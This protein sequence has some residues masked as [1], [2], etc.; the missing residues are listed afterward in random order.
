MRNSIWSLLLF[1]S[2]IFM[3]FSQT[4]GIEKGTY[5]SAAKGQ[6][7]KLNLL[8]DNKYELV[9][10][11][12][13]YEIKGDSLVFSRNPTAE[14]RFDLSFVTDKKAKNIKI[15]F[16]DPSYYSFYI[17]TQNG[18]EEI[19]YQ[20]IS[21]IKTKLDPEW[22]KTDL[23]FEIEKTD[24]LYLVYE[25]YD[26]NSHLEKYALPKDAA[27]ITIN[28]ELEVLGDLKL[29]GYYDKKTNELK[30]SE[31]GGKNP[32]VFLNEKEPQPVKK[33]KVTPLENQ[34]VSKWTYPGKVD[35]LNEDFGTGVAVDT[36]LYPPLSTNTE[37]AANF[38]FKLKIENNLKKAIESTKGASTNKY[39]VVLANDKNKSAKQSFD[40]FV[41]D[42][43]TQTGYNMYEAYNPQ[44]DVYNYYLA[45]ADDKK[46]LKNNKITN[47]PSVVV[48]NGNG[49]VLAVA[50]SDLADKSYH[51]NY[52]GDLYRKLLRADAFVTIDKIFKNKKAADADL[53]RAFNRASVLESS[54]D[55]DSDYVVTEDNPT[56]F[57]ITK[58]AVDKKEIA[59]TWKKLIEAHQKDTKPNLYLVE[60]IV[61]EIKN[62][63]FTKQLFN[64]DRILNDTDY[65]AID[66]LLK[67]SDAIEAER[68]AF[69]NKEGEIH[70]LGNV[71]SE[72]SSALQQNTYISQEGTSGEVNK[73][74]NIS[75]Y[76][77]I[78]A[79]GKGNFES[80]RNYFDYLSQIEDKDGSNTNFLKDFSTYFDSNLASEKGSPIEKLDAIYSSL[81][82]TSSYSY[83][84]WNSFKDYH[85]NLCN[86]TAWTVVLKPQNASFIKSAIVWSEY[87]LVVT[88]NNPYYLD[89]LAQLYYKDGQ[90]D[91]AIATQALAV[92]YLT[93]EVEEVTASEIKETLS[94]MQNGTY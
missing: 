3:S 33:S 68:A 36:T 16:L 29:A 43:E 93:P 26:G 80:Y 78:I 89:T 79:L 12:G 5:L 1:T 72:I 92:K 67:H 62:Q 65:L 34:T 71:V 81:D 46:W 69:N 38:N 2:G 40:A 11:T 86:S 37:M 88:K 28:Y 6:K 52:Y 9:F 56:E 70:V 54:Y 59:Q 60:T 85:S 10:Y 32:L 63:G 27:E 42:Q 53:I 77:K 19:Q 23:E 14:N 41:K 83:D 73:E 94:K 74:K 45:G 57:T 75:I 17:G 24:F 66:Y 15:K 39:L 47:D 22:T 18:T 50:K 8:D 49:D 13:G 90:K 48:L 25:E 82:P 20:R 55:Y 87:S 51:F 91:K 4:K 21:D 64:E 84:G 7:I 44:Y 61:K 58:T 30:I 76:K 31:K 35:Y